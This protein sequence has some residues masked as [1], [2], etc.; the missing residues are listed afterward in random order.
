MTKEIQNK[1][2]KSQVWQE[3]TTQINKI[4]DMYNKENKIM[5]EQ[6]RNCLREMRILIT[7]I[8]DKEV[9]VEIKEQVWNSLQN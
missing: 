5:T 4:V 1:I 9:N 2:E 7:M 6:E 8:A 3:A